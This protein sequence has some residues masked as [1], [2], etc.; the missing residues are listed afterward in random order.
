VGPALS[1]PRAQ[2]AVAALAL[3]LLPGCPPKTPAACAPGI[4]AK[5]ELRDGA[6]VL[7]RS[8]KETPG[9]KTLDVCDAAHRRTAT[10]LEEGAIWTLL[11]AGGARLLRVER[12]PNGD[13]EAAGAKG[14]RLRVHAEPA[15]TRVLQ[16][17][18]VAFGAIG[19][20]DGGAV[21][22][23]RASVPLAQ[24]AGRTA[25]HDQVITGV[26]GATRA[27]VHPSASPLAAGAFALPGLSPEE[28]LVLYLLLQPR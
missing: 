28:Q 2:G 17:D 18:G 6:G 14:P 26:D 22:F 15:E 4:A 10:L 16:P 27:Y 25:E 7:Q 21:V 13:L 3:A 20:R 19:L 23:D 12:L 8:L 9:R 5:L 11:D 24:V 1:R